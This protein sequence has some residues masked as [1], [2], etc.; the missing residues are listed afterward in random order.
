[1]N[2][3]LGFALLLIFQLL[4][5]IAKILFGLPVSG[6]VLGLV[7][8]LITLI[9]RGRVGEPLIK[10]ANN[11]LGNLSLL[12][13]P[14]G[15]GL[16]THYHLLAKEWLAISV[17]LVASTLFMLFILAAIMNISTRMVSKGNR[18]ES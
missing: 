17:A 7:F 18:D 10:T 11:L 8:L 13:I 15:V 6:P 5:E 4:G 2:F 16:M 9:I 1:M 12:F 14:A 3:V